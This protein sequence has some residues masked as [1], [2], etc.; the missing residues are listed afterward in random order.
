MHD[1]TWITCTMWSKC[2][3]WFEWQC[4]VNDCVVWM[5]SV[6]DNCKTLFNRKDFIFKQIHKSRNTKINSLPVISY[7]RNIEQD[8]TKSQK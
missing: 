5:F 1:W 7:V 6:N 2:L 3:Y 4:S 8:M